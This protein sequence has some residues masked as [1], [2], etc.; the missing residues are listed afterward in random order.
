MKYIY[1]YDAVGN[2]I[3]AS[4]SGIGYLGIMLICYTAYKITDRICRSVIDK[5]DK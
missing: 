2:I 5:E 1:E 3:K 4:C